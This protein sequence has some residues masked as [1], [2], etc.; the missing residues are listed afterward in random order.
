MNKLCRAVAGGLLVGIASAALADSSV[1][2][3][4]SS[5]QLTLVDLDLLD[6]ITPWI[7]FQD[8]T[9]TYRGGLFVMVNDEVMNGSHYLAWT[10][11][12]SPF[13]GQV[14]AAGAAAS[15]SFTVDATGMGGTHLADSHAVFNGERQI[16]Q[17]QILG[18]WNQFTISD[19]TS[20]VIMA[21]SSAAAE[22]THT[23]SGAD[24]FSNEMAEAANRI[25]MWGPGANGQGTQQSVMYH[26]LVVRSQTVWNR[27]SGSFDFAPA[28]KSEV[29]A[30]S[31]SFT[32]LSGSE[33]SG[34]LS[35][36]ATAIS[37]TPGS[38]PVPEPHSAW[39]MLVGLMGARA[40]LR[41]RHD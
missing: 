33:M 23:W 38:S 37:I 21:T 15:A 4:L 40:A 36:Y 25:E 34:T 9:E 17:A 3:K 2:A 32:N 20:L 6:G 14:S 12:F 28:S 16:G 30:F 1:S 8:S 19:K 29:Q 7:T 27:A 11:A 39:L 26:Q 22:V 24:E 5:V 13:A 31:G 35:M 10:Q 18:A 41:K